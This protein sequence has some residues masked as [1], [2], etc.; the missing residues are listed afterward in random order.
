ML[1]F[2][3]STHS[4]LHHL[5]FWKSKANCNVLLT[6]CLTGSDKEV[7]SCLL[8]QAGWNNF[9]TNTY[10]W[11]GPFI[12][13][14]FKITPST[15]GPVISLLSQLKPRLTSQVLSLSGNFHS[16]PFHITWA[17]F[18]KL[19]RT[20]RRS[21]TSDRQRSAQHH[22]YIR[23]G[24]CLPV[25]CFPLGP[26]GTFYVLSPAGFLFQYAGVSCICCT[27]L[28]KLYR[29]KQHEIHR[30]AV[31]VSQ[32]TRSAGRSEHFK[33]AGCCWFITSSD[34]VQLI[35]CLYEIWIMAA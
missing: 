12:I 3:L 23:S 13:Q 4:Q 29:K 10:C 21:Y 35:H 17:V 1:M 9:H 20:R 19:V 25:E 18:G 5:W 16:R 27:V 33:A 2:Y 32:R 26:E 24:S 34:N 28:S 15:I 31:R 6:L 22:S 11:W 8:A 7:L 30:G 14:C